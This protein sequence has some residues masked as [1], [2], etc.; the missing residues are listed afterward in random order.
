MNVLGKDPFMHHQDDDDDEYDDEHHG[1]N[2]A[3]TSIWDLV[4][5]YTQSPLDGMVDR[6]QTQLEDVLEEDTLIQELK[7][8]NQKVVAFLAKDE[9]VD[10]MI[11]F[12]VTE[13]YV[14]NYQA[15]P[16]DSDEHEA[17]LKRIFKYPYTTSEI[18]N[19]DVEDVFKAIVF[20]DD[21]MNRLFSYFEKRRTDLT[22]INPSHSQYLVR[23]LSSL[24]QKYYKNIIQFVLE[25]Q[26]SEN[27][28]KRVFVDH[29]GLCEMDNLILKL[30]GFEGHDDGFD[31]DAFGAFATQQR[32]REMFLAKQRGNDQE[33]QQRKR[34]IRE[35][36]IGPGDL[37][38][39]LLNKLQEDK[40]NEEVHRNIFNVLSD[41]VEKGSSEIAQNIT[42]KDNMIKILDT[43]LQNSDNTIFIHGIPFVRMVIEYKENSEDSE[44]ECEEQQDYSAS[45]VSALIASR[46]NEFLTLLTSEPQLDPVVTSTGTLEPPMGEM[47][48]K[49][50]EHLLTLFRIVVERY[51]FI[52]KDITSLDVFNILLDLFFKYEFNNIL[53][54]QVFSVIQMVLE[55]KDEE[56]VRSLLVQSRLVERLLEA[57]IKNEQITNSGDSKA[58]RLGYMGFVVDIANLLRR[59]ALDASSMVGPHL[60]SVNGWNDFVTN[61]LDVRNSINEKQLGGP[62]PLGNSFQP[63]QFDD[64]DDDDYHYDDSD[65]D[66]DE[67]DD[68]VVMKRTDSDD[69]DDDSDVIRKP[70]AQP[71]DE[72]EAD[73]SNF[74]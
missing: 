3:Y 72:F 9:N 20:S 67:N 27:I 47:R 36:L 11:D 24:L 1:G 16:E 50:V 56:L 35:L 46:T 73:F 37:L 42:S 18:F 12:L 17:E 38:A 59:H 29:I 14:E 52:G 65:S 26:K 69:S 40:T 31:Q 70:N 21:R 30:M 25:K 4:P 54:C 34:E 33:L 60:E 44:E 61:F 53:H 10:K 55:S 71:A 48:L 64:D 2:D 22:P 5:G 39:S 45:E 74:V 23:A 7:G 51:T 28:I 58:F 63:Y 68:E 41:V 49:V 32:L 13:E 15:P 8:N 66:D 57:Y 62:P 6:P 43:I 19:C